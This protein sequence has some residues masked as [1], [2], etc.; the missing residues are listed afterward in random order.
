MDIIT[1]PLEEGMRGDVGDDVEIAV[2]SAVPSR[3]PLAA[4]TDTRP[5]V[6]PGGDVN[7]EGLASTEDTDAT[8]VATAFGPQRSLAPA[9]PAGRREAQ[10]PRDVADPPRAGAVGAET[11]RPRR[12]R[13][14]SVAARAGRLHVHGELG[15]QPAQ[16]V[17]EPDDEGVRDVLPSTRQRVLPGLACAP[18]EKLR[19][20]RRE[21]RRRTAQVTEVESDL[22]PRAAAPERPARRV[23][24]EPVPVLQLDVVLLSLLGVG[25]D[26]VSLRDLLEALLGALVSRVEVGMMLAG[27]PA[28]RLLDLGETGLAVDAEHVVVIGH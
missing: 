5:I 7:L 2:R 15:G 23:G 17:E 16:R 27:E 1:D 6:D 8:A 11:A 3:L 9:A 20:E 14:R 13:A 22:G 28:I 4:D 24:G 12:H 26:V 25:Q 21:A 10:R 19:E 18:S